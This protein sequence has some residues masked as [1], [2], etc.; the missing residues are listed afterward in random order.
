MHATAELQY[1][2]EHDGRQFAVP[3]NEYGFPPMAYLRQMTAEVSYW[4]DLGL[5]EVPYEVRT[6]RFHCVRR[7][8]DGVF[9][10]RLAG[11]GRL[12]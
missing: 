7:R 8:D 3:L 1:A 12:L 4:E 10:Y 6:L 11:M 2:G 5:S 9:V